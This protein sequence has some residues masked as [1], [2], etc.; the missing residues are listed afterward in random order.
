MAAVASKLASPATP[1]TLSTPRSFSPS[2]LLLRARAGS[3]TPQDVTAAVAA[4]KAR[5]P[6]ALAEI[7]RL[8]ASGD[9]SER[10]LSLYLRLELDGP[11]P[12]I[13]A[14]AATD[15]SPWISSQAAE[16]L[17]FHFRF[18]LWRDY[19]QDVRGAW[20]TGKTGQ[21]ISSFTANS[22]GSPELSAGLVILQLGRALPDLVGALLRVAP[23]LRVQLETALLNPATAPTARTALLDNFHETRPASYISILEKLISAFGEDSPTRFKAFIYYAEAADAADGQAWINSAAPSS[24]PADPLA[25]RF[26]LTKRLLVKKAAVPLEQMRANTRDQITV[27]VTSATFLRE[28]S[29]TDLRTLDRYIEQLRDFPPERADAPTLERIAA[30]LE[31]E[32]FRDYSARRFTVL[33]GIVWVAGE[34]RGG[35]RSSF[36]QKKRILER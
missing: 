16:W 23:E 1:R 7:A 17:Y 6:E 33:H 32:P 26:E 11:T 22:S 36:P 35:I 29:E 21:I 8:A 27:A 25:F 9:S 28:L 3:F 19:V 18:D 12:A 24:T 5:T 20:T 30:L 4:F 2:D 14:S 34:K 15:T 31:A 13:L 10:L